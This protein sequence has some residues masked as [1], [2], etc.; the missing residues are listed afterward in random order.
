MFIINY[1]GKSGQ[2]DNFLE[3]YQVPKLNQDQINHLD[4]PITTKEIETVI[5]NL[6]T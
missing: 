4:S 1:N 2:R 3:T 6:S 5:N